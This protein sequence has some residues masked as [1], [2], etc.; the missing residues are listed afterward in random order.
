MY[1]ADV[2]LFICS[3]FYTGGN[4]PADQMA[5]ACSAVTDIYV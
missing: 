3:G 5:F 4:C 2:P 1:D